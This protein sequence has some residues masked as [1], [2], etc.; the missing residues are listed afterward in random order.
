MPFLQSLAPSL[1]GFDSGWYSPNIG[2]TLGTHPPALTDPAPPACNRAPVF[3]AG[4]R[5]P[6]A[7][8]H[9]PG[10]QQADRQAASQQEGC[11][12]CF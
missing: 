7:P 9:L 10:L 12:L 8:V 3:P 2:L 1:R 6:V 11:G 5:I 4:G